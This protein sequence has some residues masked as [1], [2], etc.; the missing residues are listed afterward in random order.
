M[1]KY[2]K[3]KINTKKAQVAVWLF[4]LLFLFMIALVYTIMTKPYILIRDKFAPNLSGTE[5]QPTLDKLDTFWIVWPILV[6]V[7]VFIW[8]FLTSM[9][10]R[11]PRIPL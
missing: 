1:R 10:Q 7:G 6:V 4:A 5:F 2:R 3:K 8:A 9:Q 11:Q